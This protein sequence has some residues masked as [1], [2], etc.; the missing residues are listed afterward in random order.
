MPRRP[1]AHQPLVPHALQESGG[2][3]AVGAVLSAREHLQGA[4]YYIMRYERLA[5][6]S[7]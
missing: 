6:Q 1:A 7:G 2:E 4:E 3:A 5:R